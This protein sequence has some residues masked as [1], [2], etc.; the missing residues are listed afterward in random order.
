M[1]KEIL[2]DEKIVNLIFFLALL[3]F[4]KIALSLIKKMINKFFEKNQ[5]K[6]PLNSAKLETVSKAL[7]SVIRFI[8]VFI[9][10]IVILDSL[11]INTRSIIATAGIGGIAIAFGA[12]TIIQ[13][14]IKGMFM[15]LDDMIRVGDFVECAGISGTVESVGLRIT[16]IRDYDGSLHTIPNSQIQNIK[17]FNRGPQRAEVQFSIAYKVSLEEVLDIIDKVS[18]DIEKEKGLEDVFV[19]KMRFLGVEELSDFSYKVKV[20]SLVK[21]NRQYEVRRKMRALIKKEVDKR[22]IKASVMEKEWKNISLMIK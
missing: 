20:T 18:K 16:R 11:G 15:I 6:N 2:N 5:K 13:D 21:E 7:Y 14:F 17:N 9:V 10:T 19:E 4:S 12:Q 8:I 3:I 1:I 22:N